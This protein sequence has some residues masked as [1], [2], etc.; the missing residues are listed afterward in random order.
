[1]TVTVMVGITNNIFQNWSTEDFQKFQEFII[2]GYMSVDGL[3]LR[4]RANENKQNVYLTR[5]RGIYM[6]VSTKNSI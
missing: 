4:N 5:L 6:T 3:K 1:M 2:I